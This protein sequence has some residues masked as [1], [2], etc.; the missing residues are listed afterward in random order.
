[1][2]RSNKLYQT[3]PPAPVV[4]YIAPAPAVYAAPASVDEYIVP[5]PAVIAAPAPVEMYIAPAP[6][7]YAAPAPVEYIAPATAVIAATSPVE[8]I[9]PAPAVYAAPAPVVDFSPVPAVIQAPTPTVEYLAPVS[10]GVQ[11]P[12]PVVESVAQCHAPVFPLSPDASDM[13]SPE[14][15]YTRSWVSLPVPIKTCTTDVSAEAEGQASETPAVM[16]GRGLPAV[17]RDRVVSSQWLRKEAAR[18]VYAWRQRRRAQQLCSLHAACLPPHGVV[19]GEALRLAPPGAG[20]LV[21][22]LR[23]LATRGKSASTSGTGSGKGAGARVAVRSVLEDH[24]TAILELECE[25]EC[26]V[27]QVDIL[28]KLVSDLQDIAYKTK[29][30]SLTIAELG[31]KLETRVDRQVSVVDMLETRMQ[32]TQ[33]VVADLDNSLTK[34]EDDFELRVDEIAKSVLDGST[35]LQVLARSVKNLEQWGDEVAYRHLR[36][37]HDRV[38]HLEQCLS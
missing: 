18:Q 31:L 36:P 38:T 30:R 29:D 3:L 12:T 23:E 34:L 9:A 20:V 32:E 28:G 22:T 24:E 37:L 4:E 26:L 8:Y 7:V 27:H 21:E 1:M 19:G 6:A 17:S 15:V 35:E 5:A 13:S 11:A 10:S 2:G 14:D 25:V 33:T 16:H